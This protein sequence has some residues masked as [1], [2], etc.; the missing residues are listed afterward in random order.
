[1]NLRRLN[2]PQRIFLGLM[3]LILLMAL[4]A[5]L[6]LVANPLAKSVETIA[7]VTH[8]P[9]PPKTP[10]P[11]PTP[12]S[13]PLPQLPA[14]PPAVTPSPTSVPVSSDVRL[15]REIAALGDPLSGLRGLPWRREL[16]F[17]LL[18][19]DELATYLR[20]TLDVDTEAQQQLLVA[21]DLLPPQSRPPDVNS[22][23][24]ILIGFYVPAQDRIV[25]GSRGRELGEV[26]A[27]FI[28]QYAHALQDQHFSLLSLTQ[29]A[30]NA[31]AARAR[32]ALIEGDA[33]LV[34]ALVV[35]NPDLVQD[36]DRLTYN[37]GLVAESLQN[38]DEL[39]QHLN[40]AELTDYESYPSSLA[41]QPLLAFP[42]REGAQF[43]FAL[44]QAD[45]WAA[46]N[47]AYADPPVSSEQIL[48]PEKYIQEPRDLP[49]SVSLPD[50]GQALGEAWEPVAQGVL[51]ELV[52]RV[53]LDQYLDADDAVEAAAGWD[54]DLASLWRERE[55]PQRQVLVI[56]CAWDDRAEANQFVYAYTELVR[57]RLGDTQ[58]V[59]RAVAP[60]GSRW[61]RSEAGDAYV[62]REGS[63][64]LLVW[65][66]DTDTM[67]T[68]LLFF[69]GAGQE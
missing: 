63:E 61:W 58:P 49:R 33:T 3:G 39:A 9:L 68:L 52:L 35:Q 25:I 55:N 26:D 12:T 44:M 57:V 37:F 40:Q 43:V 46:V 59:I 27:S 7:P 21:L 34:T 66:P 8:T 17:D 16:A 45:W 65:T 51:G 22:R 4:S 15:I 13:T 38:L 47:A 50:L 11:S 32:D 28:Q 14:T 31:D 36:P 23:A 18:R 24:R 56:R 41:M 19:D 69:Y 6:F 20:E 64:T 2:R 62:Y 60:L 1:M 30:P 5:L 67:E 48:H 10:S 53:H 54:G 29:G 42:Y